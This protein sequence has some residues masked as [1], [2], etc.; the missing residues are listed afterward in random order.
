MEDISKRLIVALD[1]PAWSE[2]EKMVEQL[3]EIEFYKV[4]LELYL[5]SGGKAVEE[6]KKRGKSV[7][8]DLKF[9]DIPNTV[10]Q[11]CRQAVKQE[12]SILD[13]HAAGGREMM[14]KSAQAVRGQAES[15][16]IP[17][18]LVVSI[19][20]LTSLNGE[21]LLE[22]GLPEIS[23]TVKA[24]AKLSQGA[25]LDGVVA[26][27]NEIGLIR[28]ACGA[29]FKIICPGVRPDWAV[30]GDQKRILTPREA[31]RRGA[32]YLVVGRP[33]T[34]ADNP[35]QAALSIL[36]EMREGLS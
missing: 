5:G 16:G 3:G 15:M 32:N 33:I 36:E 12:V 25:G 20:V 31:I 21:D 8:L 29:D 26:S 22:L 2:A 30:T 1:F 14:V 35:R 23:T 27:P 34:R 28:E 6:L 4:G 10:A 13:L 11:A 19:T 9:H 17:R 18:P 7:F 24:W